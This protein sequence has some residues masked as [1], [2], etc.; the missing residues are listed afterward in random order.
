MTLSVTITNNERPFAAIA[1]TIA[2]VAVSSAG[3]I[4]APY[5]FE[6]GGDIPGGVGYGPG[7]ELGEEILRQPAGPD[8]NAK[9]I[10]QKI[11]AGTAG[12][13][14]AVTET[15][16]GTGPLITVTGTPND[17][18]NASVKVTKGGAL[19]TAVVKVALDA[20]N[21]TSSTS[22]ATY[23][24]EIPVPTRLPALFTSLIDLTG[25]VLA[26]LN[27]LTLIATSD[28]GGPITVTFTTPASVADIATQITDQSAAGTDEFAARIVSGKYLQVYSL[29]DGSASTLSFGAGTANTILGLTAS[30]TYTGSDST[31]VI[32]NTGLTVT[33]PHT[34][35]FVVDTIYTF[36]CTQPRFSASALA[37]ASETLRAWAVTNGVAIEHTFVLVDPA[38]GA[39]SRTFAD[40]IGTARALWHAAPS[41][42]YSNFY[43]GS[44]LH[45]A[46]ATQS[47]N[48]TNIATNDA[49]IKAAFGPL[50]H[51]DPYIT[52]A[53]GDCYF[54]G[55]FGKLRRSN[56]F[57]L[58]LFE[59]RERDSADPGNRQLPGFGAVS[60]LAPD[61]ITLA[62]NET[63]ATQK[64]QAA[65]FTAAKREGG[66]DYIVRGVTRADPALTPKFKHLGVI[67]MV[68]RAARVMVPFAQRYENT[69]PFLAANGTL[70]AQEA[71]AIEKGGTAELQEQLVQREHASNAALTVNRTENIA[72]TE[73]LTLT[74]QV[75]TKAQI[76]NVSLTVGAAGTFTVS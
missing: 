74:A 43:M 54:L 69:D 42:R 32:P 63:T 3:S 15:P 34:S 30:V 37:I 1:R 10:F 55:R 71:D 53:S 38:D 65:R 39:E 36:A 9:V 56:V 14:G 11:T 49:A 66:V 33:F 19:G 59:A 68:L 26:D 5:E 57:W 24:D 12:V 8:G 41:R 60:L 28:I 73:N 13:V 48:E 58:A 2:I 76:L 18:Y 61:G 22:A 64:M 23:S 7:Q 21:A 75:Q 52:V 17:S 35:D 25:I 44:S 46:S 6:P 20:I 45:T 31:Y 29:T 16:S 70:L 50:S 72:T 67:N 47:T 4:G 27:T 51:V 40:T 62:R